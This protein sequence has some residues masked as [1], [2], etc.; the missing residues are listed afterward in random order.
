VDIT[1]DDRYACDMT[2]TIDG[3]CR[4]LMRY[5]VDSFGRY[6]ARRSTGLEGF[7]KLFQAVPTSLLPSC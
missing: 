7:F 2:N 3:G 5:P 1:Y 6:I 4:K